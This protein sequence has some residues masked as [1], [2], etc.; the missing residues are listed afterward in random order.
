MQLRHK[1]TGE[2]FE[3]PGSQ[4]D[5]SDITSISLY[6]NTGEWRL[7]KAS[8]LEPVQPEPQW[9]KKGMTMKTVDEKCFAFAQSWLWDAGYTYSGDIQKLAEIVQDLAEE[10]TGGLDQACDNEKETPR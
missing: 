5:Q 3:W 7:F 1:T 9:V 8:V 2:L 6:D 4:F 10:F